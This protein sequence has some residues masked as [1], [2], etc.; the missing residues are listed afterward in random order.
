MKV[1]GENEVRIQ[2]V[3]STGPQGPAGPAGPKGDKGDRGETGPR[4][5]TGQAGPKGD[6]GDKGER[7]ETGAAGAV[8]PQGPEGPKGEKGDKGDAFTY[9][10]FTAEQL[11]ALRGPQGEKGEKGETGETGAQGPQGEKGETGATGPQGPQGETGPQGIQGEKGDTGPQG[12]QGEKGDTGP[13][14]PAGSIDNLPIASPAQLGGVM[15][16]AKTDEMT[17]AVGVDEAGGL[18]ALPGGGESDI[19]QEQAVLASGT[20]ASGT[21]AGN[22]ETGVTVGDLRK[23][24]LFSVSFKS[25]STQGGPWR[26][27]LGNSIIAYGG[28]FACTWLF[29]WMDKKTAKLF[30]YSNGG[31]TN[32]FFNAWV[33]SSMQGSSVSHNIARINDADDAPVY[34]GSSPDLTGDLQWNVMGVLK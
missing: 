12:P 33:Q 14:G 27:K 22:W 23:W 21:T 24:R 7:G 1:I 3:S 13:Q 15:P 4:G 26:F 34:V 31:V 11:E 8:G 10:D 18:W 2:L 16:A 28:I 19:V 29:E 5:L 9:V 30:S 6:K 25:V 17:Q 32:T 20:I